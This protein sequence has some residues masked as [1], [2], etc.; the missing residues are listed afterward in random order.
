MARRPG[1]RAAAEPAKTPGSSSAA[2]PLETGVVPAGRPARQARR[3]VEVPR[4][5]RHRRRPGRGR[6]RRLRR[7]GGR[8]PL[9]RRPGDRRR[10][11][12]ST[13]PAR[14][15]RR[16]PT[17]T[18]PSTS[19]TPTA[20]STAW[21]RPTARSAGP[22]RPG[23]RS[24]RAPTSPATTSCSDRTTRR[25]TAWTRTARRSW[26]FKTAG[27]VN[28]SP[29][30]VGDRTFVAGCDSSLHVIDLKKGAE[31][32]SVDLGGQ[33]AATAAVARRQALRR[34]DDQRGA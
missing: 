29:A 32:T 25:C 11:N 2:T 20:C 4:Q 26:K 7:L 22:S 8:T 1:G 18:A 17:A 31:L 23:R 5:G 13:R 33:A 21:T 30:V 16:R 9:R 28:G 15:R 34:H 10:R 19:A 14:S 6:R 27:P 12:G 3:A 24:P